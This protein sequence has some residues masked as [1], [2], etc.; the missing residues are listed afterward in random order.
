[1]SQV[2]IEALSRAHQLF[3]GVGPAP[4]LDAG[5]APYHDLLGGTAGVNVGEGRYQAAAQQGRSALRSA[6]R[7]DAELAA[8]INAARRDQAH[9]RNLTAGVVHQA[10]LCSSAS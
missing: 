1:M 4:A 5:T 2:E 10:P 7:T 8:V 3:T 6:A 9:A